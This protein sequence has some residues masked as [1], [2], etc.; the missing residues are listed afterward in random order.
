MDEKCLWNS[1]DGKQSIQ[2]ADRWAE[3]FVGGC[4]G[5]NWVSAVGVESHEII[6]SH[7]LILD[8]MLA[9]M[10]FNVGVFIT[11]LAGIVVG[12]FWLGRYT[13]GAG[14]EEGGCHDG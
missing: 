14:W 11:I 3:G 5:F 10:T 4:K 2:A 1:V 6:Y 13:T 8:S 7:K 12:E 9:V